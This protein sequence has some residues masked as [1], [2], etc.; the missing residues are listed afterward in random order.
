MHAEIR[1]SLGNPDNPM[2]WDDIRA[3]FDALVEP[4]LRADAPVLYDA[5]VTIDEPG[6]LDR[7]L[8]LIA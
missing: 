3:K 1:R 7:I 5:L 6:K 2:S 4:I 8:E